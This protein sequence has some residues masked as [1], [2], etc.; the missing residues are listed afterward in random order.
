M[1]LRCV[2]GLS[3]QLHMLLVELL[4]LFFRFYAGYTLRNEVLVLTRGSGL[5]S[6]MHSVLSTFEL[7]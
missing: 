2:L 1:V 7:P 5:G 3:V 4:I 6:F